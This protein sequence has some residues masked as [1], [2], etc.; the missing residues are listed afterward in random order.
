MT[1]SKSEIERGADGA[2]F[3]CQNSPRAERGLL[4]ESA[5]TRV[6]RKW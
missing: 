1:R 2:P 6:W 3:F 4:L 5:R